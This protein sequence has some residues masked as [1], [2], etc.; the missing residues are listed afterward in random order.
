MDINPVKEHLAAQNL[1][2]QFK[3]T[4]YCNI[5]MKSTELPFKDLAIQ[6]AMEKTGSKT[7]T[8]NSRQ[9]CSFF[10]IVSFIKKTLDP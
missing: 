9:G 1:S 6:L 5:F 3:K 8:V 4:F 7:P 2:H 10:I